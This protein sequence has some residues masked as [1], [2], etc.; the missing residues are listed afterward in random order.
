MSNVARMFNRIAPHYDLMN[1]LLSFGTDRSWRR[2]L[3]RAARPGPGTQALDVCTGTGDLAVLLARRGARVY[4]LDLS[5]GMLSRAGRKLARRRLADRVELIRADAMALPFPDRRFDLVSIGF[6]LRNLPDRARGIAEMARVMAP[7]GRLHILEFA[8][9]PGTLFGGLFRWYLERLIP[10]LGA[11][12]A[13]AP[14]AYRY[15]ASSIVAFH[16]PREICAMMEAAGLREI[17]VRGLM[18]GVV[19]LYR[20]TRPRSRTWAQDLQS[21][22]C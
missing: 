22:H 6:G 11:A 19:A 16:G 13:G 18:G 9:P 3:V 15:L 12:L 4:G 5:A 21:D 17:R 1:H 14:A 2:H 7:G 20:G 8:P 10:V